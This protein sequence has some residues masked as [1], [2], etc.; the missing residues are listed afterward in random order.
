[1]SGTKKYFNTNWNVCKKKNQSNSI[2]VKNNIQRQEQWKLLTKHKRS[3]SNSLYNDIYKNTDYSDNNNRD[4]YFTR[5][6]TRKRKE[7]TTSDKE[8]ND[9]NYDDDDEVVEEEE[10]EEEERRITKTPRK[11]LPSKK[12]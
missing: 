6:R 11:Q 1:M 4:N 9:N 12:I 3:C 5:K 10:N 2:S 8:Q 7:Y